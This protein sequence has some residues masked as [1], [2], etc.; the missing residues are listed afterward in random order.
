MATILDS[1]EELAK[2][3]TK[4]GLGS[5]EQ[6][7]SQ[8]KQVWEATRSLQFPDSYRQVTSVVVAGM[9]GSAY[10]THVIATLFAD[11][12]TV[13]VF[14]IP[15]YTLPHWV[16]EHTLVLLSS[17]SGS[18]EE[19]LSAAEDAKKKGAHMCGLTSGGKLGEWLKSNNYP[20]YI[21]TPT[22]NQCNTPRYALGY[23]VFGQMAVLERAGILKIDEGMYQAL[24][25][26]IAQIQLEVSVSVSREKNASKLLAYDCLDRL[27]IVVVAQ[28]LEGA[29]HVVANAFNETAKTYS[30][31][32]VVP[33]L[34]HHLM[35][36]LQF[37]KINERDLFFIFA[38][39]KLYSPSIQKRMQLTKQVIEKNNCEYMSIDIA[40]NSKLGQVFE[41]LLKGTYAAFYLAFLN[42]V[43]PVPNPWVDWFKQ[44][45]KE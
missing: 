2:I 9:G 4:N 38:D 26:D 1:R 15:D 39:S 21:F 36:G 6:L 3:D 24:L 20:A 40:S 12:L 31:Y 30:E 11:E 25:A 43:D 41:L 44:S 16:N 13:P 7:G 22:F 28:H 32:R 19:T 35:E 34:N 33:E 5:I 42:N 29:G 17:Y 45:M 8:I 37:P 10:G 18:T 23:S 27:P 14:S